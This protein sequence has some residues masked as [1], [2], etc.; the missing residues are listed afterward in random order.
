MKRILVA[1]FGIGAFL[2]NCQAVFAQQSEGQLNSLW[3]EVQ[4]SYPGLQSREATVESAK[5]EER[6]VFGERLPQ[7]RAQAQNSYAT[8][9]GISGAF[10]PQPGLFNVS[11][12]N[13][14]TGPSWTFNTYAS[15]TL[16]WE[17]FS[18]GKYHNKSKAAKA[19]TQSAQGER[20][21]YGLH[22]KKE[23]S[24][25][26]L[27]LLFKETKLES[28][29]QNV[30]RLNT[31]RTIT[32]ALAKAGLKSA[33]DSL[34]ASSSYNQAIGDN[35]KLQGEKQAALIQLLELTSGNQASYINSVPS[36]LNPMAVSLNKANEVNSSHPVLTSLDEHRKRLDYQSK[37]EA[38]AALPSI[39]LIGGYAYRGVGIGED[40]TVSNNWND[41]FSNS[42]SNGL[43]GVGITWNISDLYTQ[44]QRAGS[45]EKQAESEGHR[46]KQYEQQMQAE[47][48]SIQNKLLRQYT[49]VKKTN[50][51][52][53][54]AN[55]AYEMYLSR[56][57]SGL[58]DL[59]N[60]LQIQ[61][62]VEQAEKKHIDA[63]YDFWMLMASEAELIADFSHLFNTL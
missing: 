8:F 63:A 49:E 21:A 26:Y 33:A 40:G 38:R 52:Q 56:Y 22:L 16:E 29:Q 35:E 14:L 51:A 5:M 12:A 9:E 32:S 46:Y 42:V 2:A 36:F 18:F 53:Q 17:I 57:K 37:S 45:L 61:I 7:L 31:I 13:A 47:L 58:M 15:S 34:L 10:F 55:D 20:E 28:N 19:K 25:R 30:D 54:Q 43:V 1:V 11:G 41:G 4:S 23:L 27:Q 39:K 44:K 62:F 24:Q 48:A 6:S 50:E 59:S 3:E 60:L